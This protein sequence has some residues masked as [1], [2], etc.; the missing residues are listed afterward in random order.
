[1]RAKQAVSVKVMYSL[2]L[3][4]QEPPFLSGSKEIS[5]ISSN[6]E[7]IPITHS[8]S[9]RNSKFKNDLPASLDAWKK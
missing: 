4:N 9:F 7:T 1:M 2:G 8:K 3:S 6:F 5:K